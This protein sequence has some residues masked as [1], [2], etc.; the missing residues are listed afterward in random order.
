MAPL[1]TPGDGPASR[2]GYVLIILALAV[3]VISLALLT[4]L[5]VWQTE[6]QREKEEELIFRGGQY[7]E[8]VRLFVQKNPGKFPA[9][10]KELLEKKCLRRLYRDPFSPDGEWNVVLASG[11]VPGGKEAAAE[12]LIAPER[13]LPAIKNPQVLGVVSTSTNT[14]VKIW[15]DQESHDKWLFF[16]GSD[17]K[18]PPK[19]R[20]YGE[21]D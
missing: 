14:S 20:Y 10:L 5:P 16:F 12:V 19:V 2:P 7:A 11:R 3:L 6:V 21:K 17:P 18:K 4:A 1:T 15:N 13:V 8:A 9:S